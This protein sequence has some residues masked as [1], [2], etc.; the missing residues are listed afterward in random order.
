[1]SKFVEKLEILLA[2]SND[3]VLINHSLLNNNKIRKNLTKIDANDHSQ[4]AV[5]NVLTLGLHP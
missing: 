4:W 2:Q 3:K 1:M 5:T